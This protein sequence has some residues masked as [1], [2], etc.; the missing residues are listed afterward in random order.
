MGFLLQE[1]Q[2]IFSFLYF[3]S[4]RL[5]SSEK[6]KRR[7][8]SFSSLFGQTTSFSN[9]LTREALLPSSYLFFWIPFASSFATIKKSGLGAPSVKKLHRKY[10]EK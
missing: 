2:K 7:I 9:S 3:V 5:F 4:D 10:M 8:P 1:K 6:K